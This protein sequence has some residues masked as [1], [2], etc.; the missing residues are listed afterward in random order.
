MAAKS[1]I[2]SPGTL[3]LIS[4]AIGGV[5]GLGAVLFSRLLKIAESFFY[6]PYI[7]DRLIMPGSFLTLPGLNWMLLALLAVGGLLNGLI[8]FF[9]C[10]EIRG[11]GVD[12]LIERFHHHEG[13]MRSKISFFK[14]IATIFTLA[15]GGSAGKEGPVAQIGAGFGSFF[16]NRLDIGPRARRTML[17]AGAAAGLGAIFHAP[18][19]GALTAAEMLYREDIESDSLVPCIISAIVS[20]LVYTQFQGGGPLYSAEGL[21]FSV[22]EMPAYIFLGIL[23]FVA[24][25]VFV[26][27]YE[28]TAARFA[29]LPLH[30]VLKPLAGAILV[31]GMA[32]FFPQVTGSSSEVLQSLFNQEMKFD[33]LQPS[34]I[35]SFFLL[36]AFFKMAATS[37]TVGSGSAG[38]LYGPSLLIGASL[39]TAAGALEKFLW[40]E[41]PVSYSSF[42][43]VGMGAFY[44]GVASAPIAAMVFVCELVGSYVLL[45]P[46]IIVSVL[47]LVFSH[48]WTIYRHQLM[49]RFKSPAHYWDM[50]TDLLDRVT[51]AASK[52]QYR[53]IALI[54]K[55]AGLS[56]LKTLASKIHASDFVVKEGNSYAGMISLKQID[57][58]RNSKKGV[59]SFTDR[60]IRSISPE[61]SLAAALRIMVEKELDKIPLSNK[62]RLLGYIRYRDIIEYYFNNIQKT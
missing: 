27:M 37:L 47:T 58:S 60:S 7:D 31:A 23:C 24:G 50:R 44:S 15:S 54:Q 8:A 39:G 19:A 30:P 10:P 13:R 18:L 16:A 45:P 46:L 2:K 9:F 22:R 52:I 11:S 17:L 25:F 36:L 34:A 33:A 12:Y 35:L 53:K 62:G 32:S 43:L 49:N 3:Y 29:S 59:A 38:G 55:S 4:I 14:S 6:S 61:E 5:T 51:I 40:P 20:Y 57:V 28:F 41:M 1:V 21:S 42:A 56:Q 26:R 48:R